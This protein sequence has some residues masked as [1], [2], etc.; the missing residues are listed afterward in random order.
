M[1]IVGPLEK[2]NFCL[3]TCQKRILKLWNSLI[4]GYNLAAELDKAFFTFK[5]IWETEHKPNS[6][7]RLSVLPICTK[8]GAFRQGKEIHSHAIKR[9]LGSIASVGNSLIDMYS[10]CGYLDLALKVFNQ[11][12]MKNI[13]TYNTIISAYGI[14][15]LG[16]QGLIF[17]EQM[18]MEGIRPNRV[19]FT[20]LSSACSHA[21]LTDR[22]WAMYNSMI[23]Y[24]GIEPNME[25]YCAW[26]IFCGEQ[27]IL[28]LYIYKF[29]IRMP[30][31]NVL[32]SMLGACRVHNK[33][34]LAGQFAMQIVKL[35]L[36]D[37]G[38]YVFHSN[39]YASKERWKDMSKV[40]K[41]I[42]DKGLDKKTGSSGIQVGNDIHVFHA[43]SAFH[44]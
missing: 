26:W 33:V 42:K 11:M 38:H 27:E 8:L 3:K 2:Q 16:E 35:N 37:A 31:S 41:I 44:I 24:Y 1:L 12:M 30:D 25:H 5:S 14:Y 43:T 29:I 34:E 4:V 10:K 40:R 7:T 21:G 18:K 32:G 9:G 28:K 36:N 23:K 15:G 22:G 39:L 20:V 6:V 13:V 17:Y 19:T